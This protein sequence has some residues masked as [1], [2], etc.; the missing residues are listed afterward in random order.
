MVWDRDPFFRKDFLGSVTFNL[1]DL[2]FHS[3]NIKV[4]NVLIFISQ[5]CDK[6]D[7]E[8]CNHTEFCDKNDTESCNHTEF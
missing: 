1:D 4:S 5:F 2:K 7:T 6:N 8:S 3:R